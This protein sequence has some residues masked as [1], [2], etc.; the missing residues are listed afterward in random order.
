[1]YYVK[2][3]AFSFQ[4][5]ETS[6]V[7]KSGLRVTPKSELVQISDV[8]CIEKNCL[9]FNQTIN[10]W[11]VVYATSVSYLVEHLSGVEVRHY[12]VSKKA[13]VCSSLLKTTIFK[14]LKS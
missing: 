11:S 14:K 13:L 1:M 8:H 4:Q 12:Y 10:I 6:T 7:P 2:V 9:I 3:L 5:L